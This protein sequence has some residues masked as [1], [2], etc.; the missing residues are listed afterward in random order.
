MK[1]SYRYAISAGLVILGVATVATWKRP[2]RS[3]QAS[4]RTMA[5]IHGAAHPRAAASILK[6]WHVGSQPPIGL[7]DQSRHLLNRAASA[8]VWWADASPALTL[9]ALDRRGPIGGVRPRQSL[10]FNA[11]WTQSQTAVRQGASQPVWFVDSADASVTSTGNE[12]SV[13]AGSSL[14]PG[15]TISRWVTFR[16]SRPGVYVIQARWAGVDSVPLVITVGASALPP[17]PKIPTMPPQ[18]AGVEPLAPSVLALDRTDRAAIAAG[19]AAR[20]KLMRQMWIGTP[21]DGWIPIAGQ[22]P[23]R[24]L[25][26]GW[27]RSVTLTLF[28]SLN[29]NS[30]T[31]L[32]PVN[33]AGNFS[34]IVASPYSG[35][36]LLQVGP[37]ND[38]A[39][40]AAVPGAAQAALSATWG[41]TVD[42]HRAVSLKPELTALA[43]VDYQLPRFQ[44]AVREAAAL[45]YNA[46]DPESGAIAISNW[47]ATHI[48]YNYQEDK[49]LTGSAAHWPIGATVSETWNAR[50][51]VCENYAQVLTA[52]L[53]AL[54]VRSIL[55]DGQ[56]SAG[57][58]SSWT[59]ELV[60][61]LRTTGSNHAWVDIEG[62]GPKMVATDPTWNGGSP[63]SLSGARILVSS[64]TT[65][66]FLFAASHHPAG[67]EVSGAI[68][69]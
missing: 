42:C 43:S 2:P 32:L 53:R 55:E 25:V 17:M 41:T 31:Y 56:A 35:R 16:A 50:S 63:A 49:Q 68:F 46:P 10:M 65:R 66:T 45:W 30:I 19:D 47:V 51:G 60:Y 62:L 8:A 9:Q 36:V 67:E 11:V 33:A 24:W 69:P 5:A 15:T 52:M 22:V 38:T 29:G 27:S 3:G 23:D 44:G 14:P 7:P 26:P 59:V 34:G 20:P 58:V 61:R 64:Y 39:T 57:W 13:Q 54:G 48:A 21:V 12:Y 1:K 37:S 6:S 18:V 40:A 4:P 28:N